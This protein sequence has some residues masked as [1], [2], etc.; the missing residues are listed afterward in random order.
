MSV[1]DFTVSDKSLQYGSAW[2]DI[3]KR[4]C[5]LDCLAGDEDTIQCMHGFRD[6]LESITVFTKSTGSVGI[7]DI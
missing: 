5:G 3:L 1:D 7:K 4:L 6:I 2:L